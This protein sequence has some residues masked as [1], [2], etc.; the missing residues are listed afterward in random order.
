[1]RVVAIVLMLALGQ[2]AIADPAADEALAQAEAAAKQGDYVAA[3]GKFKLAH[4]IDPRPG[5]ICNVGVAYYKAKQLPRAQLFLNRCLERGTALDPKFVDSVRTVLKSVETALRAG[6]FTP[7]DIVVEPA[8][9][10]VTVRAFGDDEAF[11]GSRVVWLARGKQALIARAEGYVDQ[12]IEIDATGRDMQPVK[13]TLQRK[14][15]EPI[16]IGGGTAPDTG[17]AAPRD[18]GSGAP[19]DSVAPPPVA[20]PAVV[21][22]DRPSK[23][24]AIAASAVAAGALA[25]AILSYQRAHD[26]A[27]LAAFAIT[28]DAYDDDKSAVKT[29]NGLMLTGT[30]LGI[31][32]AGIAGYLWSRALRSPA[33]ELQATGSSVAISG[34]W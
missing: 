3:A 19:R 24:P 28:R 29:W 30:A 16:A 17:S 1:V 33:V 11:I 26:R 4:S 22:V 32:S 25:L 8:S 14:P 31:A 15:A 6:E 2:L 18:T 21:E 10:T 7:V 12:T 23:V 9:A 27:E 20:P 13:I 34:R 5:L